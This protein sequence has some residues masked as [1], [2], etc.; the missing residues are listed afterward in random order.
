MST[1]ATIMSM[2]YVGYDYMVG[3]VWIIRISVQYI[4]HAIEFKKLLTIY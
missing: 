4:V 1:W 2:G 3:Q